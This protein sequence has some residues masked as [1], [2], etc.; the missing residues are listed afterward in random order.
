[1]APIQKIAFVANTSWSIY[2]FR[3]FLLEA[4]I[5][6]GIEVYVLAPRDSYTA[7]FENIPGLTFIELRHYKAKSI[8]PLQDILLRRELTSRYRA[9]KPSLVFHYTI[10][11]NVF[12]SMAAH[13]ARIP[14]VS[15]VTGLGYTFSSNGWLRR[16]A[17]ALY[18]RAWRHQSDVWVLNEDDRDL[19]ISERLAQP[20]QV[21]V[22][23]GEGVDPSAFFP[24]PYDPAATRPVTF[25]FVGRMIRSKGIE[26]YV[27][28]AH[29]L[30]DQGV[31]VRCQ[32]LG[33]FDNNPAAVPG[34]LLEKWS[35]DGVVAWLGH[36]DDV[37]AYIEK[38][39]CIVLPSY[40]EG[41][42][43]SLLE[44]ASM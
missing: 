29:L 34:G 1:M 30:R 31:P 44:A 25:L 41:M 27:N 4:L 11:A 13:R 10:K 9:I 32:V 18:R 8:S 38:A 5:K 37:A 6:K 15:V 40:R 16:V 3:L 43:L 2:K 39:D 12:G 19:L 28:A 17:S 14:S 42:P 36:T 22:L 20:Q 21:S 7:R 33:F 23:P 26:E 35:R 24:A